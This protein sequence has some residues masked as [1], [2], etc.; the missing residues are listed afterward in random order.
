[1]NDNHT[2]PI[3]DI[4]KSNIQYLMSH[5][6]ENAKLE[7]E[8]ILCDVLK[9]DKIDLYI[10]PPIINKSDYKIISD[11][12]NQRIDG[13]PIQ[14]ILGNSYF[15]GQK[16]LVNPHVLIPRFDS[17]LIIELL[18][19]H[20]YS[21]DLLDVG[22]GSGN[23]AITIITQNLAKNVIATDISNHQIDVAQY[24]KIQICPHSNIDFV[25]DNFLNSE[26]DQKFDTIISNPPYIP[27]SEMNK[28]DDVVKNYEPSNAL[29]DGGNG[30]IFYKQFAKLG[31][32]L[33]KEDGVM[34][35]EIGI[36]N[37]I[38]HLKKIFKNYH[39]KIFNDLNNIPRVLKIY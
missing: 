2:Y 3:L 17:E 21:N 15:Y 4:I 24:N 33:L 38:A 39:I 12:I 23:L 10:K 20:E 32:K 27:K 30:Y 11:Y 28:L 7:V 18:T 8:L 13:E 1:M 22:T 9:C 16:F 34:F 14:Y 5:N 31:P 35:L 25:I 29:T 36:N 6:I 19:K 26:L 37:Q